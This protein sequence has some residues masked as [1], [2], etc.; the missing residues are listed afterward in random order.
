MTV[1][2]DA[3]YT[4]D[5]AV[6]VSKTSG[7][8]YAIKAAT[9]TATLDGITISLTVAKETT[10]I[11]SNVQLSYVHPS[12]GEDFSKDDVTY[13]AMKNGVEVTETKWNG[14][15]TGTGAITLI[16]E[17]KVTGSITTASLTNGQKAALKN[18]VYEF[19]IKAE[20]N[21]RILAATSL[22]NAMSDA[23]AEAI[24]PIV[25]VTFNSDGDGIASCV[26]SN[27][28]YAVRTNHYNA[29]EY[30]SDAESKEVGNPGFGH[31]N[32]IPSELA[33]TTYYHS[34]D[35]IV[36]ETQNDVAVSAA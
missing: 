7:T 26:P 5:A 8:D 25:T 2:T 19:D 24:D 34:S 12:T 4:A 30:V 13:G 9:T 11:S 28:Y 21:A 29:L 15:N 10:N 1:F 14:T 23:A 33:S 32:E 17:Y 20:G 18:A 3:W 22:T 36:I 31:K 27:K 6:T 16:G 35:K